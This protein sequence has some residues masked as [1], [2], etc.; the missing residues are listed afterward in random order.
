MLPSKG[1]EGALSLQGR[2][3]AHYPQPKGLGI[4]NCLGL[5]VPP[6]SSLGLEHRAKD[7]SNKGENS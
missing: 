7:L 1:K 6:D 5:P 4:Y 3:L 2:E